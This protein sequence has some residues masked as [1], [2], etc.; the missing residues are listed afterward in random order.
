[1]LAESVGFLDA[2]T[3]R[4]ID[5]IGCPS[6]SRHLLLLLLLL[7]AVDEVVRIAQYYTQR[8]EPEKAADMWAKTGQPE[9]A[10]ELYVQVRAACGHRY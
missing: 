5:P 10:V 3:P 8:G 4:I 2:M 1:L 7:Q 6:P 9:R